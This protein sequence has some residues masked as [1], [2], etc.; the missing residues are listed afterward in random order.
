MATR[1][2][3]ISAIAPQTA[4]ADLPTEERNPRTYRIDEATTVELLAMLNAEDAQVPGAVAAV[5]PELARAVDLAVERVRGGGRVHYFG[6]GT[7]GR[8]GVLD[9]AELGP[10]FNAPP[11]L[12]VAHHAGGPEALLHAVE[13]VED[14][15][16]LGSDDADVVT[17]RDVAIGLSASGRTPYVAGALARA[18]GN[19]AVTILVT[20]DPGAGLAS[21]ADVL[22]APQTGPEAV[23][24]STR[25]KAGSAQ[26]LVLNGFS[27]ALM[28]RLGRTWSNLMVDV[29]PT[30]A[31]LRART[32]HILVQ[33][34]GGDEAVCR[35]ALDACAGELKTALVHLLTGAS[36]QDSRELLRRHDGQVSAASATPSASSSASSSAAPPLSKSGANGADSAPSR[37]PETPSLSSTPPPSPDPD[38]SH[39]RT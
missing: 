25:L 33:A 39:R 20:A 11:D 31:K 29:V 36:P 1:A 15:A 17:S 13:N 18:R 26:K 22:V 32:V 27:T 3:Q 12:V 24:G 35:S 14:S 2:E 30:N 37:G 9:A 21:L 5:L 34:T 16:Q 28:V 6:A 23:S 7:S 19:G 4:L 10:T 38:P 8:L